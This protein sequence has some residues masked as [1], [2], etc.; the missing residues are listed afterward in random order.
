MVPVSA[1]ATC[2]ATVLALLGKEYARS[3][4]ARLRMECVPTSLTA[5]RV[6]IPRRAT[7]H[8]VSVWMGCAVTPRAQA[9]ATCAQHRRAHR[10]TGI[11]RF[12]RSEHRVPAART[13]VQAVALVRKRARPM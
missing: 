10:R 5:P 8:L 3:R 4:L 2:A 1:L 11:V 6:T 9:N 7:V 13:Y 12:F